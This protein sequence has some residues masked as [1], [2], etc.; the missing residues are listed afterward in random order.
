MCKTKKFSL[1]VALL[2]IFLACVCAGISFFPTAAAVKEGKSEN[3]DVVVMDSV[4]DYTSVCEWGAPTSERVTTLTAING[5]TSMGGGIGSFPEKF[6]S[7]WDPITYSDSLTDGFKKTLA[8]EA[9]DGKVIIQSLNPWDFTVFQDVIFNTP[10][11]LSETCNTLIFRM[12]LHL[13]SSETYC[14]ENGVPMHGN[15]GIW[16]YGIGDTGVVG[17]GVRIPFDITQDKWIDF[18]I[19]GDDALKL[20]DEDGVI[21]G[22]TMASGIINNSK[23]D[24]FYAGLDSAVCID[25]VSSGYRVVKPDRSIFNASGDFSQAAN[26]VATSVEGVTK[27]GGGVTKFEFPDFSWSSSTT[28]GGTFAHLNDGSD[29]GNVLGHIFNGWGFTVSRVLTFSQSVDR[30]DVD[31]ITIRLATHLSSSDT[32]G[33]VGENPPHGGTGIYL[34]APDSDGALGEGVLI[35]Y[36]VKQ[37]EWVD[38]MITGEQLDKLVDSNGKISGFWMG[39]GI[40]SENSGVLYGYGGDFTNS[41]YLLIDSVKV[42]HKQTVLYKDDNESLLSKELYTGEMPFY[43]PEKAGKAFIGWTVNVADGRLLGF[44]E[45]FSLDITSLYAQWTNKGDLSAVNGYYFD[46]DKKIMIF[47]DGTVKFDADYGEIGYYT[48]GSNGTLYAFTVEERLD[49]NLSSLT[50]VDS[51]EV[52]YMDGE[53]GNELFEK[54]LVEKGAT[55]KNLPNG[56]SSFEFWSKELN[57]RSYQ[58]SDALN[59]DLTLYAVNRYSTADRM[60]VTAKSDY[61]QGEGWPLQ[62]IGGVTSMNSGTATI[63]DPVFKFHFPIR[64]T[65]V[66]D[67]AKW[68]GSDD[69]YAF[70]M[71]VGSWGFSVGTPILFNAPIDVTNYDSITFRIFA[72]FSP[73]SPYGG[74]LWGGAGVRIFGAHSDGSDPGVLVPLDVQQDQWVDLTVGKELLE[75]LAD[76]DGYMYGFNLGAAIVVDTSAEKGKGAWHTGFD[77]QHQDI[78]KS[79][80]ILI[81]Y[82]TLSSEKTMSFVDTDGQVLKSQTF[83]GGQPADVSFVPEKAGKVFTG[84]TA[85]EQP[86]NYSETFNQSVNLYANWVDAADVTSVS[87][88][89]RKDGLSQVSVFSDGSVKVDGIQKVISSGVGADGVAYLATKTGVYTYDLSAYDKVSSHQVILNDGMGGSEKFL[90]ASGETFIPTLTRS[91]YVIDKLYN[92]DTAGVFAAGTDT[93]HSDIELTVVWKYDEV[94]DY[95]SVVGSYYCLDKKAMLTL[96]LDNVATLD[97]NTYAYY[98]LTSDEII[99]EGLGNGTYNGTYINFVGNYVK[100]GEFTVVFDTGRGNAAPEKQTVNGGSYKAVKPENPTLEGYEFVCWVTA[101]GEEFNF[102]TVI[103]KSTQLFAKWNKIPTENVEDD[104]VL[105]PKDKG[106]NDSS[107]LVWIIVSVAVFVVGAGTATTVILIKKKRSK[108]NK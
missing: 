54:T 23:S 92:V 32:Y 41:A 9:L 37:D 7:F 62:S 12:Y 61:K 69:G 93:V 57:G 31:G 94:D 79:T 58:F 80:Y 8:S 42:N 76:S 108:Q 68:D 101:D 2:F 1:V 28:V 67:Y 82:I 47:K 11:T 105:P 29:D 40:I 13:S 81:D 60:V 25:R 77:W 33:I 17:E 44:K 56:N 91:G 71:L 21:K 87:G 35:P 14:L 26:T 36:D 30:A 98:L 72:H 83:K 65:K 53:F 50:K 55:P 15:L 45:E 66:S 46:G 51:V 16:I 4:S 73:N 102:D 64:S 107:A 75:I 85:Y 84:W 5:K 59:E 106:D 24:V 18:E 52:V 49:I 22:F 6:S 89:Y 27:M 86:L 103:T 20:A 38:F 34:F 70:S 96:K 48:Y 100:L 99:I 43:V 90:V 97:G 78:H 95:S 3:E 104:V 19:S 10:I 63:T 74:N 88:L 39:S